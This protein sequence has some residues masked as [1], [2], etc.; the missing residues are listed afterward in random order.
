MT[1]LSCTSTKIPALCVM[2]FYYQSSRDNCLHFNIVSD[3]HDRC[4]A[5]FDWLIDIAQLV[6]HI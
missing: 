4:L 6:S 3:E 1:Q 2:P 5:I